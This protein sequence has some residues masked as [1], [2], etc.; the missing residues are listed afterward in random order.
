MSCAFSRNH[1][2]IGFT[3]AILVDVISPMTINEQS[4]RAISAN[5]ANENRR[6]YTAW[7]LKRSYLEV[8]N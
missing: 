5:N 2:K 1:D 3:I 4:I 8:E 7:Y 6:D